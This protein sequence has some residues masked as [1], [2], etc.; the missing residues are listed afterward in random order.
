MQQMAAT[1]PLANVCPS[2]RL[3]RSSHTCTVAAICA[4]MFQGIPKMQQMAATAPPANGSSEKLTY[5]QSAAICASYTNFRCQ[6]IQGYNT[7]Q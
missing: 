6:E 4:S 2:R 3:P 5:L 7:W 1:A